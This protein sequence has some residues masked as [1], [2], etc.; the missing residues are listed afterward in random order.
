M[1]YL[2]GTDEA[3]YGP[4]LGPLAI[5]ATVWH[6]PEH[7]GHSDM[8]SEL[9]ECVTLWP[10][11]LSRPAST[12]PPPEAQSIDLAADVKEAPVDD[13]IWIADSKQIY[14]PINPERSF[15]RLERAVF[16]AISN[17]SQDAASS[18][19]PDN[20][21]EEWLS[22]TDW[23]NIW[24]RL[25]KRDFDAMRKLPWYEDY[26]VTLPLY[27]K[28]E[29][30]QALVVSLANG[31]EQSGIRLCRLRSRVIDAQQ[32]NQLLEQYDNKS[33][34][35][36]RITLGLVA[37]QIAWI[38][39]QASQSSRKS[40]SSTEPIHVLCDKHG[41]RARYAEVLG[42]D[43]QD[44]AVAI[45]SE[46][47]SVSHYRVERPNAS[48]KFTFQAKAED[49]LA[50][51]LASMISKYLRELAMRSFNAFWKTH[52]PN[53]QPTAGYPKDARRFKKE[54]APVQSKLGITDHAL[55]RQ[56]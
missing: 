33:D 30:Y 49:A 11:H 35:L 23:S 13:R 2:I 9:D 20:Q 50:V 42:Q 5:S 8:Y 41:G 56:R 4:N 19:H 10:Q 53:L 45:E 36:S 34:L 15:L 27:L 26:N 14:K 38:D 43:F 29:D 22:R 47:R 40:S 24:E 54:I 18:D 55:W 25:C 6:V 52:A 46:S 12:L 21:P 16:S 48:V 39:S 7:V 31:L 17:V 44:H 28:P 51:G 32:F 3:G 1:P 37:D